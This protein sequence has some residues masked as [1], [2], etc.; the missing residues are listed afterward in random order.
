MQELFQRVVKYQLADTVG[1]PPELSDWDKRLPELVLKGQWTEALDCNAI[2]LQHIAQRPQRYPGNSI[3]ELLRVRGHIWYEMGAYSKA[4]QCYATAL[5]SAEKTSAGSNVALE[6]E[7]A[8]CH[9]AIGAYQRAIQSCKNALSRHRNQKRRTISTDLLIQEKLAYYQARAGNIDLALQ[10]STRILNL[11]RKLA[12]Q[13]SFWKNEV[14]RHL[15]HRAEMLGLADQLSDALCAAQESVELHQLRLHEY[16]EH[17]TGLDNSLTTLARIQYRNHAYK[18]ALETCYCIQQRL[19]QKDPKTNPKWIEIQ[20]LQVLGKCYERIG[21]PQKAI[22]ALSAGLENLRQTANASWHWQ[23]EAELRNDLLRLY[24]YKE[25]SRALQMSRRV[26]GLHRRIARVNKQDIQI[27]ALGDALLNH[28]DL[29]RHCGLGKLAKKS[30]QKACAIYGQVKIPGQEFT[31]RAQRLTQGLLMVAERTDNLLETYEKLVEALFRSNDLIDCHTANEIEVMLDTLHRQWLA[32]FIEQDNTW[33][34]LY[35]LVASHGRKLMQMH[36]TELMARQTAGGLL[37]PDE[38]RLVRAIK[39]I[40]QL[41]LLMTGKMPG[42]EQQDA[43]QRRERLYRVALDCRD[44]LGRSRWLIANT[45]LASVRIKLQKYAKT[46]RM[47]IWLQPKAWGFENQAPIAILWGPNQL[48]PSVWRYQPIERLSQEFTDWSMQ[49]YEEQTNLRAF[50]Q[51][52]EPRS[53]VRHRN[54]ELQKDLN[55]HEQEITFEMNALWCHLLQALPA[56]PPNTQLCMVTHAGL[57]NF[58]FLAFSP[59]PLNLRVFPSLN[60][61][62]AGT[63]EEVD[64]G[65]PTPKT[66]LFVVASESDKLGQNLPFVQLELAAMNTLWP[67]MVQVQARDHGLGARA[68]NR[69]AAIWL[70]GHGTILG[71]GHASLSNTNGVPKI[72]RANGLLGMPQTGLIYA[73]TCHLGKILDVDDEPMGLG[74]L[75]A[76]RQDP[77]NTAA[78]LIPIDDLGASLMALLF[79]WYWRETG[80]MRPA[81]EMARHTLMSASWPT[82]LTELLE[83]ILRQTLTSIEAQAATMARL[84][85]KTVQRHYPKESR[86]AQQLKQHRI[87]KLGRLYLQTC[88]ALAKPQTRDHLLASDAIRRAG[89]Y[90]TWLG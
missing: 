51:A 66:P 4:L 58:P 56:N 87:R 57:H 14:A 76:G 10:Q 26:I 49:L 42:E 17:N 68:G 52:E 60:H 25:P 50:W 34:M 67:E 65:T 27:S 28:A 47:A 46:N 61:L 88:H 6:H 44:K 81:F 21:Q 35:L 15:D 9:A 1:C 30:Y 45:T 48:Q 84:G 12:G 7:M 80:R 70:T 38:K 41:D 72:L 90:W 74:V 18:Q 86:A 79:N 63:L 40:R 24:Y 75:V 36:Q 2:M 31:K 53:Q 77:A 37:Q 19:A 73:S 32:H 29:Q 55:T 33:G 59:D 13:D 78:S 5:L 3:P 11:Q 20:Y 43:L 62:L 23:S 71:K 89:R 16:S 54:T 82:A 22:E 64:D 69:S 8:D 83:T 85:L 39:S